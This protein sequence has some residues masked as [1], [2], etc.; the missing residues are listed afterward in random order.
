M[1]QSQGNFGGQ[2]SWFDIAEFRPVEMDQLYPKFVPGQ[3][4]LVNRP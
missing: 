4:G 3:K 1:L 2:A